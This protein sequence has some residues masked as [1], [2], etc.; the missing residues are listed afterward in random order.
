MKVEDI[1]AEVSK[2]PEEQ[3]ASIASRI[4]HSLEKPRYWVSDEEVAERMDEAERDPSVMIS[5]EEF[6]AGIVRSGS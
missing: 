3:R 2:L 5:F 4:I 1:V 6:E